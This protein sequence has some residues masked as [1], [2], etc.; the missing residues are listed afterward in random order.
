MRLGLV[1]AGHSYDPGDALRAHLVVVV[2][3]VVDFFQL[4]GCPRP[5]QFGHIPRCLPAARDGDLS[6]GSGSCGG[7]SGVA[8][9]V[10]LLRRL[11]P[12]LRHLRCPGR[13]GRE[14]GLG[15]APLPLAQVQRH[16][17]VQVAGKL[18][19][20]QRLAGQKGISEFW[21]FGYSWDG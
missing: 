16:L 21:T 9:E 10:V 11:L 14:A 19:V 2:V 17:V 1:F 13:H 20:I 7:G 4:W 8:V 5:C 12:L 18:P 15:A 6:D 3:V